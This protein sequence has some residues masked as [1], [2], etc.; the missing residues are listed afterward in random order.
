MVQ[1]NVFK[2]NPKETGCLSAEFVLVLFWCLMLVMETI[3]SKTMSIPTVITEEETEDRMMKN[4]HY[5]MK[6]H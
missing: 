4:H 3:W 2:I 5:L 6:N 1:T